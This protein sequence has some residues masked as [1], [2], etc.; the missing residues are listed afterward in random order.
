MGRYGGHTPQ[1]AGVEAE[2]MGRW[3]PLGED[4][5]LEG[6]F[7]VVGRGKE[8]VGRGNKCYEGGAE[9]GLKLGGVSEL[10]CR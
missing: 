6:Y 3:S 1:L 8:A 4:W 10:G 2:G 7:R 9:E 5:R